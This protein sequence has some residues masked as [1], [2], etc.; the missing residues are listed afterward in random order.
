MSRSA[1]LILGTVQFGLDYGINN[2]SGQVLETEVKAILN[3]AALNGVRTLDTSAAYGNSET[4][5]GKVL[6]PGKAQFNLISKYPCSD[7]SVEVVFS[8][9]LEQ[10]Q[11]KRLYGYLVHHFDFYKAY[12]QIWDEMQQLK[13][14]EKVEKIGFSL[15]TPDQ[16]FYLLDRNVEFDIL[17]IPYNLLDRQFEPYLKE[18]KQNKIEIHTRSVFLQGL[19]FKELSSLQADLFP[20]RPYL[21]EL[22][23]YCRKHGISMGEL[24]LNYVIGNSNIDGVLIGVDNHTQLKLNLV[25]VEKELNQKDID[26]IESIQVKETSLLSPINWK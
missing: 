8:R 6:G 15:Y 19:F 13:S 17:Q 21:T 22:H 25:S 20:L 14:K 5:L 11:Q 10:L 18:L 12:P 23:D 7:K 24:A 4:V 9:S 3:L 26:F 16:L 2:Q 1:K